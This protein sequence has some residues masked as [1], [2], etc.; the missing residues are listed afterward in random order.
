MVHASNHQPLHPHTVRICDQDRVHCGYQ[1][2]F[3][4]V[5]IR[6]L[7]LLFFSV[8]FAPQAADVR[9]FK[10]IRDLQ[11]GVWLVCSIIA[12][13][14]T[15]ATLVRI[16]WKSQT[17]FKD[18]DGVVFRLIR[19]TIEAAAVPVIAASIKLA[20]IYSYHDNR[21]LVFCVVLGRLYSN[22]SLRYFVSQTPVLTFFFPLR[23]VLARHAQLPRSTLRWRL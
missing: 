5:T 22:V 23:T 14:L 15:S 2:R 6:V 17:G 19:L 11:P 8:I 12:D 10:Y 9:T 20:L 1:P 3:F 21:H 18:T 13:I 4:F 7:P 16:L